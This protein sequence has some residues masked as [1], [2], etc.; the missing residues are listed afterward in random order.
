M[1]AAWSILIFSDE[2]CEQSKSCK[3]ENEQ[4]AGW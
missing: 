3:K 1:A 2:K 4:K